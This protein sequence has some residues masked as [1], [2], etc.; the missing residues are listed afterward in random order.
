MSVIKNKVHVRWPAEKVRENNDVKTMPEELKATEKFSVV[1]YCSHY[2]KAHYT[3]EN[4]GT[5]NFRYYFKT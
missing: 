2:T 5:T 4:C 3:T 1:R